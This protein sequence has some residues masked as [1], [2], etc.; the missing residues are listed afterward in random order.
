[1]FLQKD[2]IPVEKK[3]QNSRIQTKTQVEITDVGQVSIIL[4]MNYGK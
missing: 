2:E 1:M 3:N 4:M